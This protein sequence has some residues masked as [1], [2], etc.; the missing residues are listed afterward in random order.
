M[1]CTSPPWQRQPL[2]SS[3][4]QINLFS[5][6]NLRRRSSFSCLVEDFASAPGIH[7]PNRSGMIEW[8]SYIQRLW[9]VCVKVSHQ[10]PYPGYCLSPD[11]DPE[12]TSQ[13]ICP[14]Q[15]YSRPLPQCHRTNTWFLI[16][17]VSS[18]RGGGGR[19]LES[20]LGAFVFIK[21]VLY[22]IQFDLFWV[23][24]CVSKEA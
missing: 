23:D 8:K 22:L 10:T 2:S 21:P 5:Q 20:H 6:K 24:Y 1:S 18:C 17:S 16:L 7:I 12:K 19:G 4:S 15:R 13:I 14:L 3:P 9:N 11:S